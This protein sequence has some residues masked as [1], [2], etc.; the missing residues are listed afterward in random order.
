[1]CVGFY[2]GQLHCVGLKFVVFIWKLNMA[3]M[4]CVNTKRTRCRLRWTV[5]CSLVMLE[6][7]FSRI[8][9]LYVSELKLAKRETHEWFGM[10]NSNSDYNP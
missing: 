3:K 8:P 6:I 7:K 9:F 4:M 2:E 5:L 10:Q 1:M